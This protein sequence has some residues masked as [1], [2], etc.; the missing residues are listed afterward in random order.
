MDGKLMNNIVY[1]LDK[2]LYINLTNRCTNKCCFCIR[3]I[4]DGVGGYNLWLDREPTVKEVIEAIGDPTAYDQVVFCG[5]GEPMTRLEELLEISKYLKDRGAKVRVNTN[6]QANLIHGYNVVPRLAGLV[7][8]ISVSL[9][10]CSAEEYHRIC[11]SDFGLEAYKGV[12][13]FIKECKKYIKRVVVSVVNVLP[14]ESIKRCRQIAD[15][16]GVEFRI[17]YYYR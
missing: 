10:A 7:D 15:D 1:R 12:V 8:V 17:R 3:D 9:N 13:D 2:S 14:H 4:S 11:D 16:L 5:Y 6:G